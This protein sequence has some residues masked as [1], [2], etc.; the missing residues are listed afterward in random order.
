MVLILSDQ[1]FPTVRPLPQQVPTKC[2]IIRVEDCE[3]QELEDVFNDRLKFFCKPQ[4][5]FPSGS[6]ILP[7]VGS[8]SHLAK[9]DLNFYAPSWSKQ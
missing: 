3:L 5:S 2:T 7:L 6:V 9:N 4:C 8:M 1:T